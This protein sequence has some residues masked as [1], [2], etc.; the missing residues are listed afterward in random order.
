VILEIYIYIFWAAP[1]VAQTPIPPLITDWPEVIGIVNRYAT[2]FI[3]LKVPVLN[4]HFA[5]R[6]LVLRLGRVY[7]GVAY[8]YQSRLGK[9]NY[10]LSNCYN[11]FFMSNFNP[12]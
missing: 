11:P 3:M 12:E 5:K 9:H 6:G 2:V 4:Y 10:V 1:D 8:N 7:V